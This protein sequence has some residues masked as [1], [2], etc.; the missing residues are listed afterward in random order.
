MSVSLDMKPDVDVVFSFDTERI[1]F[2]ITCAFFANERYITAI[3][4]TFRTI[5]ASESHEFLSSYI[6]E[7]IDN[8][9]FI[10]LYIHFYQS[11]LSVSF[12]VTM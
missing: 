3:F 11:F 2:H 6:T 5:K 9:F 8:I 12:D 10:H 7:V 1:S 4:L